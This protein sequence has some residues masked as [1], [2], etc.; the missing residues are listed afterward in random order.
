MKFR[1]T[2]A[3]FLNSCTRVSSNVRGQGTV[4]FAVLTGGLMVIVIAFG[5][6][7]RALGSGL[8]V[9]HALSAASHH[10]DGAALGAISD[11]LLF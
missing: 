7:W 11:V 2:A 4:E 8:F 9:E 3:S 10:I 5:L 6:L 1:M